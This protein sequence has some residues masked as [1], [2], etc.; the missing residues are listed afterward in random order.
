M[1]GSLLR[2]LCWKVISYGGVSTPQFVLEGHKL[3]WSHEFIS[4]KPGSSRSYLFTITGA[5]G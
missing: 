1:V 5:Y 3:W 4:L 2:S